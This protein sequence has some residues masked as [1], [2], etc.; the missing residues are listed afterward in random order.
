MIPRLD[1]LNKIMCVLGIRDVFLQRVPIL[2]H[3]IT[4][5]VIIIRY[6]IIIL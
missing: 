3:Y 2:T 6:N 4:I 1:I 5:I